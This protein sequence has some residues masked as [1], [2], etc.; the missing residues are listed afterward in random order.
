MTK[1]RKTSKAVFTI[2]LICLTAFFVTGCRYY[3]ADIPEYTTNKDRSSDF[4]AITFEEAHDTEA[5][6]KK[7]VGDVVDNGLSSVQNAADQYKSEIESFQNE[8]GSAMNNVN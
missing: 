6:E 8:L 2:L 3:E 5:P 7:T 4:R 1:I